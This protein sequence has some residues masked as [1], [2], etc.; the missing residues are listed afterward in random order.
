MDQEVQQ[1]PPTNEK[2]EYSV[3]WSILDIW[4]GVVMLALI[5]IAMV[6][7]LFRD[8]NIQLV[9]SVGIVLAELAYLLPVL[10]I[11]ALRGIHW[12]HIGFGKF[13][14]S[15]MGLG[16]GFLILGYAIIF[17]VN[18]IMDKLG[19]GTQG[20]MLLRVFDELDSPFWFFLVG[21]VVAPVVEEIFFRGFLFQGFRQKYGW[22][23]AVFLS[24]AIF[25]AAHFDLA[26]LFPTFVLGVVLAYVYH[27]S[28]S[29]WPGII[30]HFLVNSFGLCLA[31]VVSQ[32]P[33]IIP[34]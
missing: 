20:E 5:D 16:C 18:L 24:S 11:F 15:T 14:W 21:V 6:V 25:G 8:A 10:V 28:N 27:R 2:P 26:S 1:S 23:A 33:G 22:A 34:S 3:P 12:R 29:V 4:L 17:P 30:L 9:Q 13:S 32:N 19:I 31:Y 7:F